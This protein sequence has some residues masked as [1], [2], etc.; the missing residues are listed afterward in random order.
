[1]ILVV[2]TADGP[3]VETKCSAAGEVV[4]LDI[5]DVR[6]GAGI[7][8]GE[9]ALSCGLSLETQGKWV[10]CEDDAPV[11]GEAHCFVDFFDAR[12]WARD[13]PPPSGGRL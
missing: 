1:M 5:G 4:V 3:Q 11:G 13:N 6:C 7:G 10:A 12:A 2:M 9:I 8:D